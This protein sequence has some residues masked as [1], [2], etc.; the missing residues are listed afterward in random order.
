MWETRAFYP[1]AALPVGVARS[2]ARRCCQDG[3]ERLFGD[4]ETAADVRV[5]LQ[6]HQQ[7]CI[8]Q[9]AEYDLAPLFVESAD[10]RRTGGADFVAGDIASRYSWS[11]S[12][13]AS[14]T[15]DRRIA[16]PFEKR[17]AMSGQALCPR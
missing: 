16:S 13:P 15:N 17:C 4:V 14:R 2:G 6:P 11:L 1:L 5:V 3:S 9:R 8:H 10:L 12:R 7:S